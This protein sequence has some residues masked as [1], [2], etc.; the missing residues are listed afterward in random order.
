MKA[1]GD[2][3]KAA[4][5]K[6]D[7]QAAEA[8][9]NDAVR[10][11]ADRF[12][13]SLRKEGILRCSRYGYEDGLVALVAERLLTGELNER[14]RIFVESVRSL[15]TLAPVVGRRLRKIAGEINP[16]SFK[17]YLITVDRLFR[18]QHVKDLD[19]RRDS[20]RNFS[21]E[22]LA[23]A[24]SYYFVLLRKAGLP[25]L[26]DLNEVIVT[27]AGTDYYLDRL[28]E[29]ARINRFREAEIQ[30]EALPYHAVLDGK[31]VV[32]TPIEET[33]EQATRWGYVRYLQ[34]READLRDFD[35]PDLPSVEWMARTLVDQNPK[36]FFEL[37]PGEH[38][39]VRLHLPLIEAFSRIFG[40]AATCRDDHAML[41]HLL[42][43]LHL[44]FDQV[45][46][47]RIWK[48]ITLGDLIRFQ[49]LWSF[50][51]LALQEYCKREG[52]L[53]TPIYYRSLITVFPEGDAFGIAHDFCGIGRPEDL[54]EL[55][56]VPV[57]ESR[58]VDVL[59]TPIIAVA[60][61][62]V[63][64]AALV[65][66]SNIARNALQATRYRFDAEGAVDPLSSLI[67]AAFKAVGVAAAQ[68]VTYRHGGASGEVDVVAR[69]EDCVFAFECK[70]SLH[71]CNTAELRQSHDHLQKAF[72]QLTK[73]RAALRDEAFC[74]ALGKKTVLDLSPALRVETCVVM[75][76]HM[77]VGYEHHGHAVR[78]VY[79]LVNMIT[80]G[81][82]DFWVPRSFAEP[83]GPK[84]LLRLPYWQGASLRASD[85]VDYL[86]GDSLH[87]LAF[88]AMTPYEE[89]VPFGKN[90]LRFRSFALDAVAYAAAVRAHPRAKT[91]ELPATAV[92][93]P[94]R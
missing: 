66:H 86:Q 11:G 82:A 6:G 44:T 90:E 38:S 69:V 50:L 45:Q 92:A 62:Y 75:G 55:L 21:A 80:G 18:E 61:R 85:L 43:S 52:L 60:Q 46:S 27:K 84:E 76:N 89:V 25:T 13:E 54:Y 51:A 24:F 3:L 14:N 30:V 12:V 71:P 42:K 83:E 79:E 23:D 26:R 1:S 7:R 28:A 59:Y 94:P 65:R 20:W 70:H 40:G 77:F 32:V 2:S 53:G 36:G 88:R 16:R 19:L 91:S 72:G 31:S 34:Q 29:L 67:V 93:P 74:A 87:R 47:V 78:N 9:V 4:L 15:A 63:V 8:A 41:S 39:R 22:E 73:L 49:R 56:S 68:N 35:R 64:P 10:R 58:M 37:V 57:D 5:A 33:F 48:S 17:T 81:N